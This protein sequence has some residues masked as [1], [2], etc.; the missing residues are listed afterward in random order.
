[1]GAQWVHSLASCCLTL[2]CSRRATAGFARFRTRLNS[3]VRRRGNA[4]LLHIHDGDNMRH[5]V[6]SLASTVLCFGLLLGAP[7]IASAADESVALV[8]RINAAPGREAEA[9]ARLLLV[10]AFVR[11]AEP[12][13]TYRLYRS[14]KDPTVFI[15]YEVYQTQAAYEQHSKV[16]LPAFR[17]EY[18]PTPEGL[19]VRPPE[20]ELLQALAN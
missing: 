1:V 16:T 18:G 12:G 4:T 6:L 13:T 20:I 9:E 11:K 19:Y 10:V 15:F 5:S 17:K 2:R 3:N 7:S 14:S 8:A